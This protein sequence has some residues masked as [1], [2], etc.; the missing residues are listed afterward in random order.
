[1]FRENNIEFTNVNYFTEPLSEE[2]LRELLEKANLSPFEVLRKNEKIYKELQISEI[3][4]ADQLIELIVENPAILQRPFVEVGE[5]AIL[6][7]PVEKIAEIIKI[8]V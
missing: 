3:K 6:A 7:R 1:M 5:K 8:E 2:K 4:D